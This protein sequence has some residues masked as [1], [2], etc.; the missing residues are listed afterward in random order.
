MP[1]NGFDAVSVD[2]GSLTSHGVNN[3]DAALIHHTVGVNLYSVPSSVSCRKAPRFRFATGDV[4]FAR[5]NK[6]AS[7]YVHTWI[8]TICLCLLG[9]PHLHSSARGL[10]D[11]NTFKYKDLYYFIYL[12]IFFKCGES[13]LKLLWVMSMQNYG[14]N[15]PQ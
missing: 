8:L 10:S 7:T 12:G 5:K 1:A 6:H 11:H 4:L 13:V 15:I 9:E 14:T 2:H 3:P